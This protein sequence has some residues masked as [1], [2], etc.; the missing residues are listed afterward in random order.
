[1]P[2][3]TSQITRALAQNGIQPQGCLRFPR[4]DRTVTDG[5]TFVV[6]L[7]SSRTADAYVCDLEEYARAD[8]PAEQLLLGSPLEIGDQWAVVVAY[9]HGGERTQARHA[10]AVGRL[11]RLTHDRVWP[12]ERPRETDEVYCPDDWRTD[13]IIITK[14]GAVIVDLDLAGVWPRSRAVDVAIDDFSK[15]FG[16]RSQV[17]EAILRGYGDHPDLTRGDA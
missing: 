7:V 17:A 9:L 5:A 8:V 16:K 15:P 13:N 14:S 6:K 10:A 2:A 1:M 4:T 11:L 12:L 3:T